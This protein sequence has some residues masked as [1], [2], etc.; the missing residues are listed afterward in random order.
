MRYLSPL[1]YPGGKARL[2]PYLGRLLSEQTH[3]PV[4]YAEPFAGGAGAALRLL[5]EEHVQRIHIND[6]NPG[7]A[8]FWRCVFQCTESFAR[9]IESTSMTMDVW[10]ESRAVYQN[11]DHHSDFDLGFSTFALN[12]C[13]RSGILGARPIGGLDQLG[14]WKIDARYNGPTLAN[15]VRVLGAYRNRVAISQQDGRSFISDLA[16]GPGVFFYVDPPYLVPGER[17][18]MDP[19][20]SADHEQLAE[21]LTAARA[22]W[23]LTYDVNDRVTASLYPGFRT[24]EFNIKHTAQRQHIGRE[25]AVFSQDLRVP[26]VDLIN[27]ASARWVASAEST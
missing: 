18:Y 15:R 2:A 19:L 13:N 11:P 21:V 1:R 26:D 16:S 25:Y 6:L 20:G 22:P 23:L 7:I 3:R 24:L 5:M 14:R 9:R 4:D 27:G 10:Y 17:L 8:A 12:R